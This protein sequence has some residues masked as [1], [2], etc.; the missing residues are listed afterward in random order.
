MGGRRIRRLSLLAVVVLM[1]SGCGPAGARHAD[2]AASGAAS[3]A[4][5]A[6]S[7]VTP[8]VEDLSFADG[9]AVV[10]ERAVRSGLRGDNG[11]TYRFA[12]GTPGIDRL[13]PGT[14]ALLAGEAVRKVTAVRTA[15]G[16]VVVD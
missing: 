12:A 8:V 9:T 15:G 11:V 4:A 5:P 16:E 14:V 10:D 2:A 7:G 3:G 1:L 6:P 13:R